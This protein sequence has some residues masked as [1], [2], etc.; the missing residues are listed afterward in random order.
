MDI[1]LIRIGLYD[2][3]GK[4]KAGLF[5]TCNRIKASFKFTQGDL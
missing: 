2:R 1:G 5:F 4:Y 3:T